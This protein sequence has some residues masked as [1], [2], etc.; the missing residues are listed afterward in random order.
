MAGRDIHLEG[1]AELR[2]T[3]KKIASYPNTKK[4]ET[5][6]LAAARTLRD[7]VKAAAPVGKGDDPRKPSGNLKKSI[8]AGRYKRRVTNVP[9]VFVAA[10]APHAFL[11]EYGTDGPRRV[12]AKAF[13]KGTLPRGTRKKSPGSA[14]EIG[15]YWTFYL[16]GKF[17]KV[18]EIAAMPKKAFFHPTV[19][20]EEETTYKD[21][22]ERVFNKIKEIMDKGK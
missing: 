21:M 3:F 7:K 22:K 15:G 17:H 18:K 8:Y 12:T 14:T 1:V 19:D 20:A 13:S 4:V 9:Q 2:E 16:D 10:R 11:V 5:Q 6:L